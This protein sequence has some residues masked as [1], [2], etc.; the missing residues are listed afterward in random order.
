MR[1]AMP[2]ASQQLEGSPLMW[3]MLLYVN[4][5]AYDDDDDDDCIC[6]NKD[7]DQLRDNRAADQHLCFCYIDSTIS[8]LSKFRNSKAL[9]ILFMVRV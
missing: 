2:A 3:M 5:N 4:L 6:I 8:P 7:A 1:S 9:T